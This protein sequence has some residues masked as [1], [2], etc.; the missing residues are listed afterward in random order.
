MKIVI[1]FILLDLS[2]SQA[3]YLP[4]GRVHARIT[5]LLGPNSSLIVH[6]QSKDDDLGVHVIHFNEF[7]DWNFKPHVFITNTLFFCTLQWNDKLLSFDAYKE[8]RDLYG[9]NKHCFWDVTSVGA[10]MENHGGG[11]LCFQWPKKKNKEEIVEGHGSKAI[12]EDELTRV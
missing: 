10:C 6:C 7:F 5:N 2:L 3:G 4:Y 12:P 9:C 8:I 11:D 1:F